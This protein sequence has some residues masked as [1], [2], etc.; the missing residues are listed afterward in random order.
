M[1]KLV[2]Q[3][4]SDE[5]I[6]KQYVEV[7][8]RGAGGCIGNE[9]D[10]IKKAIEAAGGEVIVEDEHPPTVEFSEEHAKKHYEKWYVKLKAVHLPWGG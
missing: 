9:M 3:V 8:V 1:K 4:F 10:I 6:H 2:K 5:P 7:Q